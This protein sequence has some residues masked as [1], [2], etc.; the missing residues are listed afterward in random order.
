V[1]DLATG[2]FDNDGDVDIV[3]VGRSTHNAVIYWNE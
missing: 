1:E 2:D 3:A